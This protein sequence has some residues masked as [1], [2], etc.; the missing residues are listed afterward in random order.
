M[1]DT[2]V[3]CIASLAKMNS[4]AL[5]IHIIILMIK[6]AE[7]LL[8]LIVQIQQNSTKLPRTKKLLLIELT[9]PQSNSCYAVEI[10][11]FLEYRQSFII[12]L[13]SAKWRGN[14]N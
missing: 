2:N 10:F 8:A 9:F 4:A 1:P 3:Y 12:L 14:Y 11:F 5:S 6:Y 7:R 13:L